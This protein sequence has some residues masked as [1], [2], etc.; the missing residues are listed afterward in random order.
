MMWYQREKFHGYWWWRRAWPSYVECGELQG[1]GQSCG[2]PPGLGAGWAAPHPQQSAGSTPPWWIHGHK[3]VQ[4]IP[5][6]LANLP[7]WLVQSS[8]L[9]DHTGSPGRLYWLY[10]LFLQT[11]SPVGPCLS[12]PQAR[13]V[14]LNPIFTPSLLPPDCRQRFVHLF[15]CVLL[16]LV[17][18]LPDI[19]IKI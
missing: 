4:Q 13:W 14:I 6:A 1:C 2:Q 5:N 12:H 9:P 15:L 19:R 18:L 8:Q 10:W 3:H 17:Q 7:P 11:T 16:Q